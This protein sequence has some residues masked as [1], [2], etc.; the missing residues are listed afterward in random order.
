MTQTTLFEVQ[1][2][3]SPRLQW[4]KKHNITTGFTSKRIYFAFYNHDIGKD[5]ISNTGRG[6]SEEDALIDFAKN[7]NISLWNEE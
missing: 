4:M 3:L 5:T 1:E 7:N 2:S 6:E